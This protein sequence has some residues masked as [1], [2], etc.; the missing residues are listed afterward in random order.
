MKIDAEKA[1][2]YLLAFLLCWLA[3]AGI[4]LEVAIVRY[5]FRFFK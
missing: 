2:G 3:L 4:I 5:V 1:A